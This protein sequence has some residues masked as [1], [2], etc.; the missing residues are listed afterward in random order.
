MTLRALRISV[1][2]V[3]LGLLLLASQAGGEELSLVDEMASRPGAGAAYCPVK[4]VFAWNTQ[5]VPGGGTLEL[6]AFTFG[7]TLGG[8]PSIAFVS[9]IA[10]VDRNQAIFVADASGLQPIAV[11]CG[12]GGGS[13][14]PGSGCG[15][16]SPI[17]GTFS[18]LFLQTPPAINDAGDVLFL[19]DVDGGSSYRG[20]FLYEAMSA[21]ITKVAAVGDPS[22]LGSTL[23]AVGFGSLNNFGQVVFLAQNADTGDVNILLYEAGTLSKVAAT[24][25]PA[26]RAAGT[27]FYFAG[28][29]SFPDGTRIPYAPVPDINDQGQISFWAWVKSGVF[30]EPDLPIQGLIVSTG[31]VHQWY[32]RIGD[33]TPAGGTYN[34]FYAPDLNNAGEIAFVAVFNPTPTTSNYG[35]FVGSPGDWRTALLVGDLVD[36]RRV[37][38]L[39][40]SR[41]PMQPLNDQGDLLM[42]AL[43]G[44]AFNLKER[45]ILSTADG[46]LITAAKE[47]E[48]TPLGGQLGYLQHWPSLNG[49]MQG[50]LSAGTPGGAASNAHMVFS[51]CVP[52]SPEAMAP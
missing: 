29:Q 47:G 41:N 36:G 50:T 2:L 39:A 18:G 32:V 33:P 6:Q 44:P 5:P 48:S 23:A 14:D 30:P 34:W 35:W 12:S 43:T 8:V 49:P 22:P 45:L 16:P 31:G 17:G 1:S 7:A 13:G 3:G 26:P 21:T 51:L 4:T 11:G 20:L 24:G 19:A 52:P 40:T 25:E 9:R 28:T 42:W 37:Q 15:D 27:F 10:G 46:Y 38:Q